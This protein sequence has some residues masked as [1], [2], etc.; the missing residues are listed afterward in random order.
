MITVPSPS[1]GTSVAKGG[2]TSA[3]P[4]AGPMA[5]GTPP[6]ETVPESSSGL[7]FPESVRM[8]PDSSGS[9]RKSESESAAGTGGG[10]DLEPDFPPFSGRSNRITL[11]S[12]STR[13]WIGSPSM[14]RTWSPVSGIG[15]PSAGSVPGGG[16]SRNKSTASSSERASPRR[17]DRPVYCRAA[18]LRGLAIR[19][20]LPSAW[21]RVTSGSNGM[22]CGNSV[23]A[24]TRR[25]SASHDPPSGSP[26]GSVSR[27]PLM[28]TGL[29]SSCTEL[30]IRRKFGT[31]LNASGSARSTRI[32]S[33]QTRMSCRSW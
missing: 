15:V 26:A 3:G 9:G 4:S 11:L 21:A 20:G 19:T 23:E 12:E 31:A 10:D 29:P 6:S 18:T 25:N 7:R 13:S 33:S 22:A 28:R 16:V 8:L 2:E 5:G 24:K 1:P 17:W 27:M 14:S 30:M 32:I